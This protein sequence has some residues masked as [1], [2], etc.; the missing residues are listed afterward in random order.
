MKG[1]EWRQADNGTITKKNGGYLWA[2][3]GSS[4]N[5]GQRKL[6]RLS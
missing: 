5:E 3:G 1:L 6:G 2:R 4:K